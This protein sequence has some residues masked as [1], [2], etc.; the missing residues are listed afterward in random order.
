MYSEEELIE[1]IR[2][3]AE[4][5][6]V[7]HK[8]WLDL[9][10]ISHKANI[11]KAAI[12]LANEGGGV[13]IL[14]MKA[15]DAT[16]DLT[17]RERP[18]GLPRYNQDDV[19]SAIN[20]Y[21]DPELNTSLRFATH[22]ETD[23]EHAFIIVPGGFKFP[24][25]CCRG[26]EGQLDARRC[27]IRKPGPKSEEPQTS[28]EWQSLIDRCV[29]NGRDE[30]IDAIRL[31]FEGR[32][33]ERPNADA[34]E[35]LTEFA[36]ESRQR[37]CQLV[38]ALPKEDAA[39]FPHGRYE[40]SIDIEDV[41]PENSLTDL[42]RRIED[43][44]KLKLT[45]WGPFIF[46]SRPEFT[47]RVY[48]DSVEAWIGN[49]VEDRYSRSPSHCDYWRVDKEH[50]LFLTRGFDEDAHSQFTPG[51]VFDFVM[52]VWRIGETLLYAS[53]YA[54]S[55]DEDATLNARITYY[56]LSGRVLTSID[57]MRALFDDRTMHDDE[58]SLTVRASATEIDTNLP[59]LLHTL[60]KPLYERFD[61]FEL[62][63]S[64]VTDELTRMRSNR[65]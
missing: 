54:R 21:S 65:F 9:S 38:E 20:R 48:G 53:R 46:M 61:F 7:E 56:G 63:K 37:W 30:M 32:V 42:R 5:L 17:S 64:M 1:L 25:M 44:G 36:D 26:A 11:A 12:A 10:E 8:S 49:P 45:G 29:R 51:S 33:G 6:S 28:N 4:T 24:I 50:H 39:R 55:L 62:P 43:A 22:P 3:P 14:G 35:T 18:E 60:L 52:P 27:Y 2:R 31:I 57:R 41:D 13:I 19:N 16:Q 34:I 47:P 40:V 23:V 15:E 58:V 59:E